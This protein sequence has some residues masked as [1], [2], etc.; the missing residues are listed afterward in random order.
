M[1]VAQNIFIIIIIYQLSWYCCIVIELSKIRRKVDL[2]L[3]FFVYQQDLFIKNACNEIFSEINLHFPCFAFVVW[4]IYKININ[5]SFPVDQKTINL[6]K[7]A[8]CKAEDLKPG[9]VF[10][11]RHQNEIWKQKIFLR[12]FPLSRFLAKTLRVKK[13]SMK[14]FSKI[15]RSESTLS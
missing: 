7:I 13:F 14:S 15:C 10:Q 3:L 5:I 1:Y 8:L 6:F 11:I 9:F 4:K 12:R 2:F